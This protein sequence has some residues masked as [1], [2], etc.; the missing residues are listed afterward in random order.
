MVEAF[1]FLN[2]CVYFEPCELP[3]GKPGASSGPGF[4]LYTLCEKD[5][6]PTS[7]LVGHI[8]EEPDPSARYYFRIGYCP[9]DVRSDFLAARTLLRP[10]MQGTPEF[11]ELVRPCLS[12]SDDLRR[13]IEE[14]TSLPSVLANVN[15]DLLKYFHECGI[16]QIVEIEGEVFRDWHDSPAELL[17]DRSSAWLSSEEVLRRMT[18]RWK[19]G[20]YEERSLIRGAGAVIVRVEESGELLPIFGCHLLEGATREQIRNTP[21]NVVVFSASSEE[22]DDLRDLCRQL[23]TTIH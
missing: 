1:R 2:H 3:A 6:R 5:D 13:R 16:P 12:N 14:L 15:F 17:A 21:A 18:R 11:E 22:I 10:G 23:K 7:L 9:A 8:L 19:G 4:T 20:D